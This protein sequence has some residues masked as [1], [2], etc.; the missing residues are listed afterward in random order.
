MKSPSILHHFS[1]PGLV[2]AWH[3]LMPMLSS[4]DAGHL[5]CGSNVGIAIMNHPPFITINGWDS[6]HQFD[7]WFM[8]LLYPHDQ[9]RCEGSR[10]PGFLTCGLNPIGKV[11]PG[12]RLSKA[13]N[14]AALEVFSIQSLGEGDMQIS[15]NII[16]PSLHIPSIF[17]VGCCWMYSDI[18][19]RNRHRNRHPCG[20]H[21]GVDETD[22]LKKKAQSML[23]DLNLVLEQL[24][25]GDG[26]LQGL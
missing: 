2:D 20:I 1:L 21:Q 18:L 6:N 23:P 16:T 15:S 11:E 12:S 3:L 8:T 22:A 10:L 5:H 7:G 25:S 19:T 17:H 13:P 26:G 14:P 24:R 4:K 9:N